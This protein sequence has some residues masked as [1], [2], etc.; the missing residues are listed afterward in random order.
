MITSSSCRLTLLA[1]ALSL[2]GVPLAYAQ[3]TV[4]ATGTTQTD[5]ISVGG[6]DHLTVQNGGALSVSD[7]NAIK[8][9]DASTDLI[10]D[11]Y[12]L[13]ESTEDGGRAI[14]ASGSDTSPRNITLNN[15]AGG[16]IQSQDDAFR[17]N[18]DITGG[19]VT[20][21][22]AGT[23]ESTGG[24]QALDFD[25]VNS[26]GTSTAQIVINNL[27]GGVIKADDADAIRPGQGATVNN[28]G[29][30]YAD[31]PLGESHDGVDF[32]DHSGTV[33]NLSGGVISGQ[34]HG[35]TSSVDVDVYNAAGGTITGR[36]GSGVGSDG[37]GSVVNY[38]TITGAYVGTGNGDGDGVDI[39][40]YAT[41][42]N[43]GVIQ[44]TGAAGVDAEGNTNFSEG[45]VV[46][47]GGTITNHAGA[48][49]SGANF[50]V[51][52]GG[53]ILVTND[54]TI[55][56]TDYGVEM[57]SPGVTL[58]NNGTITGGAAITTNNFDA[59]LIIQR[60]S[61]INGDVIGGGA[62][63]R[64]YLEDG[65][66]FDTSTGFT[67]LQA[68]GAATLSGNNTIPTVNIVSGASLQLG[69]G[70]TS[71]FVDGA[72]TNN[73]S[74]LV[75][76]TD[77]VTF[78][79]P[80]SGSGVFEQI[81]T[82]TTLFNTANSY[83]GGTEVWAGTLKLGDAQALVA[84]SS[85]T[86]GTAGHLDLS[87]Y[88][89]TLGN[90]TN[91][92]TIRVNGAAANT[93][94]TLAG[95]YVGQGGTIA[96]NTNPVTGTSDQIVLDG[97]HASASGHTILAINLVGGSSTQGNGLKVV[98]TA[99]GATIGAD[100]FSL[101]RPVMVE[102]A[103]RYS[104][105]DIPTGE[106]AGEY[107]QTSV[108]GATATYGSINGFASKLSNIGSFDEREGG[109]LRLAEDSRAWV[110][111]YGSTGEHDSPNGGGYG[112][113]YSYNIAGLQA[114]VD[115]YS[116]LAPSL[117]SGNASGS[118]AGVYLDAATGNGRAK[119][120]AS[121]DTGS[122]NGDAYSLGGYWTKFFDSGLYLDAVVQATQYNH[123]DS[124]DGTE[125]TSMSVNGRGYAASI[126]AGLTPWRITDHL[127]FVP[128]VQVSGSHVAMDDGQDAFTRVSFSHPWQWTGRAGGRLVLGEG[129]NALWFSGN[130]YHA[131]GTASVVTLADIDG[132]SPVSVASS[133]DESWVQLGVGGSRRW[134]K[135]L[136]TYAQFGINMPVGGQGR[137]RA[138]SAMLGV[139][140]GF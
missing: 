66:V 28:S 22:N 77:T 138:I 6:T 20:V 18:I 54:G 23:I 14:N 99:D 120:Q 135:S 61:V 38:G 110:R 94:L 5:S 59:T 17:I 33:N 86:V 101:A 126:E 56:G 97:A 132:S 72:I 65:A 26:T 11:N 63:D 105:M 82:G 4:I 107:L 12:G 136:V 27:A 50:G 51:S 57:L 134:A 88:A 113:D 104:L 8:W 75:D 103:Y 124:V 76:R 40:G 31:G 9:K 118:Q 69:T 37:N 15:Y 131:F 43:F 16:V 90:V 24:G 53:D 114:G 44:G 137:E 48:T 71:G 109:S 41:V 52:A 87:G 106:A 128:E 111:A 117:D 112:A 98:S 74:L 30:I 1:A 127:Q 96:L 34:R 130:A 91:A 80:I 42:D 45:V 116:S 115:L 129:S 125:Q 119:V 73:G 64:I 92:G 140:Y 39:D 122:F 102:G 46:G 78:S 10:I 89:Q 93:T 121:S 95:A 49:I 83:T 7:D 36:N 62:D 68:D 70:G 35:I 19:I 25:A 123:I 79:Q 60:G 81:G 47:G 29:L 133:A 3:D 139:K 13:I 55:S 108:R 67:F 100:T 85:V 32:Q 84:N 2:A 58:I 21:N